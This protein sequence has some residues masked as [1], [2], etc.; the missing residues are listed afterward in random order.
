LLAADRTLT[1]G[2]DQGTIRGCFAWRGISAPATMLQ[3]RTI[4][5]CHRGARDAQPQY[6]APAPAPRPAAAEKLSIKRA[7][8]GSAGFQ[9]A[10]PAASSRRARR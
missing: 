6:T 7:A 1:N 4:D 8:K 9:P 3:L 5:A 2:D 10:G